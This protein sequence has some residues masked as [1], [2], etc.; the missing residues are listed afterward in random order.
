MLLC[1]AVAST[2]S[3]A[4]A[5]P[6]FLQP[7]PSLTDVSSLLQSSFIFL[8]QLPNATQVYAAFR[9]T[10][11][12]AVVPGAAP[13]HVFADARYM[14]FINGAYVLRGPCRFN[15]KRPE[16]D[17]IDVASFLRPGPNVIALLNHN[18]GAGAINGRIMY[19]S[20]GVTLLLELPSANVTTDATWRCT[21]ATEY[22]PSPI[23][24]SSIPD[25]IDG[26]VPGAGAWPAPSFDDS[27]WP[28]AAPLD[29]SAFGALQP[30]SLPLPVELPVPEP[31][32]L[33]SG[34]PLSLPLTLTAG[35]SVLLDLGA[36]RMA[37]AS[38]ALTAETQGAELHLEFAL[39]Y[40][41]GKPQETYGVGTTYFARSGAQSFLAGDI[42]VAHYVTVTCA[43]GSFTLTALNFTD[44]RYPFATVGAF[45][46]SD[47]T[48]NSLWTRAV[49]TLASTTD[50]AYGSDAR[51]RN[52]WL[53]DP[54]EPNFIT[55][56]VAF[57]GPGGALSDPRPLRNL[58]R[59]AALSQL[60]DGRILSTFPTDRGP[61][62]CHY[63][64]EDYAMQ[65][66]EALRMYHEATGDDAFVAEM[67]P[68]L[69]AQLAY[70]L[71][72]IT[73]RG[74]L[75]ARQYTSFDDPLAYNHAEGAALN[76]FFYKALVDS[77]ALAAVVGETEDA[78]RFSASAV[79][80]AAAFNAQLWNASA[81]AFNSGWLAAPGNN[82]QPGTDLLGPSVHGNL[83]ALERGV[84][85]ADRVNTT[86]EWFRDNFN[87]AGA[88]H[89][90]NNPDA[91]AMVAEK[92][93]VAMTV[94]HYWVFQVLFA[95]DT[96]AYDAAAVAQMRGA[97]GDMVSNS[98]DTQTLWEN[99]HGPESCHNYGAVPAYFLSS[100][101]LGVRL[102][103][104]VW[105]RALRVEP[106][107][108][109][110]SRVSGT[111]VTELGIVDA[112]F[113]IAGGGVLSFTA[114]VPAG[115]A[116][117]E[118]RFPDADGSTL[119]LNGVAT[120]TVSQGR[121]SVV[122]VTNGNFTGTIRLL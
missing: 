80:L 32:V 9:K 37:Y 15:P 42:W 51:E 78:A 70:F 12:V 104:P 110:L 81:G 20:P 111:V 17:T 89:C 90:C 31:V 65:W 64:I 72:R 69:V 74:L 68:T 54:A 56:R 23:A 10:F 67:Y 83:L 5:P 46:S 55:T 97:W 26:R 85:P 24:W 93:G 8:P 3:S 25:V 117:T 34:V 60:S 14:L 7:H 33:P 77:A 109:G 53:Q 59:H 120:A 58:L 94:T 100:F 28:L 122:N 11:S 38:G 44:R 101:V 61:E 40:V 108:G 113:A 13:L 121:W 75:L 2:A 116:V 50:D 95:A 22:L 43:S 18:Y 47:A 19:H 62:D 39:R 87:N 73:P 45:N 92:A 66:V 35:Q 91:A 112:A 21:N 6:T 48:L 99:L 98:N 76:A 96:A 49:N 88:L 86:R 82:S 79:N 29:G 119:V 36:M 41:D 107:L 1:A 105:L 106:R 4:W 30:R 71:A 118:L 63:S 27:S 16:F 115:V 57:V 84:V 52:E 103:G 114:T 102:S